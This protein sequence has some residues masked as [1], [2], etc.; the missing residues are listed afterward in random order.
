MRIGC[1]IRTGQEER[2]SWMLNVA[3]GGPCS[4][5]DIEINRSAL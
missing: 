3:L 5:Q 4:V 2:G 1:A